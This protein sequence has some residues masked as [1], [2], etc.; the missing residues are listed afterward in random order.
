MA[1]MKSG[2]SAVQWPVAG[3]MAIW[4]GRLGAVESWVHDPT[5]RP[6]I[7]EEPRRKRK[8]VISGPA[9]RILDDNRV[10]SAGAQGATTAQVT[11]N[12][13][14]LSAEQALFQLATT[15]P[16]GVIVRV[17]FDEGALTGA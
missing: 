15:K 3:P 12:S 1:A 14:D 17:P 8:P 9:G 11:Y 2:P 7:R 10:P 5:T 13:S 6:R 4:G 16:L